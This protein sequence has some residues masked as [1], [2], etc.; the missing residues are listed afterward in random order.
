M[1]GPHRN[2][3][4]AAGAAALAVLLFAPERALATLALLLI[5]ACPVLMVF[6][7]RHPHGDRPVDREH[8]ATVTT[9][10]EE[11]REGGTYRGER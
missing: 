10:P 7:L 6:M 9:P 2:L 3:A 1:I 11:P 8:D 4:W 5:L